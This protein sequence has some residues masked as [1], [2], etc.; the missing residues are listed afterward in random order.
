MTER[1]GTSGHLVC[2]FAAT[3]TPPSPGAL[4]AARGHEEGG[5]LRLLRA[6]D[7]HLVVQDVPAASFDEAA[8]TARLNHPADL[9]R[10]ARAHHRGVEAAARPGPAVPLPMATLYRSDRSAAEAVT[11]REAA[12]TALLDRLEGRTEWAV[13]VHTAETAPAPTPT[14]PTT[15]TPAAAPSDGSA[16][17]A[18]ADGRAYLSRASVR[19]RVRQDAQGRASA[20]ARGVDAELRRYAVEATRHRPQSESL[21]GRRTPQL[22]NAAYLVD[23]ARRAE[24]TE[25]LARIGAQADA[26]GVEIAVSG[27]WIPYSFARWDEESAPEWQEVCT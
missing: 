6:G 17:G 8:L 10:C 1:P 13:K 27:P 11:S 24:F 7:L 4:A 22:L 14:P 18:G 16:A 2:A 5:P 25:A 3:R 19:R 20:A 9:E 12:L 15:P 21:T 23:D 26:L